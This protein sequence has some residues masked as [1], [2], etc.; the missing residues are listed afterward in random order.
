MQAFAGDLDGSV[1]RTDP[2]TRSWPT[3]PLPVPGSWVV[4]SIQDVNRKGPPPRV[5]SW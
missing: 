5:D 3:R 2:E 1:P 4:V